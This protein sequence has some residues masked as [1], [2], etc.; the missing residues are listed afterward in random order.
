MSFLDNPIWDRLSIGALRASEALDALRG[1][2]TISYQTTG[3]YEI[4]AP[5][6]AYDKDIARKEAVNVAIIAGVAVLVLM[7][8]VK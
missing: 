5:N 1:R 6:P 8:I 4:V 7:V 3:G 2:Q